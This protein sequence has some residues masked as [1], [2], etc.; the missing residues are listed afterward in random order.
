MGAT[1][2]GALSA[3]PKPLV[4]LHGTVHYKYLQVSYDPGYLY[5]TMLITINPLNP[6]G[7]HAWHN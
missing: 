3:L 4:L 2:L 5:I 6:L 1:Q 7:S